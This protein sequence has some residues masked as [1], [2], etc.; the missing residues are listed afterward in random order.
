MRRLG[1]LV[2]LVASSVASAARVDVDVYLS[3]VGLGFLA[4]PREAMA[5]VAAAPTQTPVQT[6]S[7][8][9]GAVD[10]GAG[11]QGWR[12]TGM[13]AAPMVVNIGALNLTWA[14]QSLGGDKTA[15]YLGVKLG[16]LNTSIPMICDGRRQ[17][18][19]QLDSR[20]GDY[21]ARLSRIGAQTDTVAVRLEYTCTP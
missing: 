8:I 3:S 20:A 11:A 12:M 18:A 4:L 6:V 15:D 17:V 5:A 1:L 21:S 2:A 13:L 9:L 14:R 10:G 19:L 16:V 7:G